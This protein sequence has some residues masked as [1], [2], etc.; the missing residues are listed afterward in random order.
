MRRRSDAGG[1]L[2]ALL[3]FFG[4]AKLAE[5]IGISLGALLIFLA[6]LVGAIV[7]W[8]WV[9]SARN[10]PWCRDCGS[11]QGWTYRYVRIDGGPDRRY[12]SNPQVCVSCRARWN[13]VTRKDTHDSPT[14]GP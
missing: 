12:N 7:A 9:E 4:L 11:K 5:S 2:V 14:S 3:G 13:P 6:I 1:W 8:V 10:R